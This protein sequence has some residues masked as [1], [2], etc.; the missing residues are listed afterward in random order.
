MSN[1]LKWEQFPEMQ[2]DVG[3]NTWARILK[4]YA[5][6]MALGSSEKVMTHAKFCRKA[7][8]TIAGGRIR[9]QKAQR[10]GHV[11]VDK[12]HEIRN[13]LV[14]YVSGE[15]SIYWNDK[16]E[17]P[18]PLLRN[19]VMTVIYYQVWYRSGILISAE[20]TGP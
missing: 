2:D 9:N 17:K 7:R 6:K 16:S 13:S 19:P 20:M 3:E 15:S 12:M 14:I 1:F 4:I 10:N 18:S 8:A 5:S 11:R